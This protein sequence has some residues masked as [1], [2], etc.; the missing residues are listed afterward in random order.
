[1]RR[2]AARKSPAVSASSSD[3]VGAT[4]VGN[5]MSGGTGIGAARLHLVVSPRCVPITH[6][7]AALAR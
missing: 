1:M 7:V 5:T 6:V 3:A 2:S 4:P